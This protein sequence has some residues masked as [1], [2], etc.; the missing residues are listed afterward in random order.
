MPRYR[1]NK[2]EQ[3]RTLNE[4]IKVIK[5]YTSN[6]ARRW[7]FVNGEEAN[8]DIDDVYDIYNSLLELQRIKVK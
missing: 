5:P 7:Y 4:L 8:I 2:P 1:T 3:T 6:R